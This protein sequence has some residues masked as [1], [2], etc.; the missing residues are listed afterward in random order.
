MYSFLILLGL[1]F[2]ILGIYAHRTEKIDD[3]SESKV[4]Y[5]DI[6]ELVILEKRVAHIEEILFEDIPEDVELETDENRGETGFEKYML[7]KRYE[8]E[9]Y[10]LEEICEL[11][12]MN[13]GEILL[14][15]NLY[16]DYLG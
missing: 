5:G 1:L 4:S 13:K 15:K 10:L 14:L 7:L 9:G 11:L 16:K 3:T 6:E 2:I 12:N 8:K